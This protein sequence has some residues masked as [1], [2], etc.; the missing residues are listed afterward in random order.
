MRSFARTFMRFKPL[1]RPAIQATLDAS[2][3]KPHNVQCGLLQPLCTP[4][5]PCRGFARGA[6]RGHKE[7]KKKG[8]KSKKGKGKGGK[9][10]TG[11]KNDIF[12]LDSDELQMARLIDKFRS[13]LEEIRVGRASPDALDHIKVEVTKGEE[14]LPL[15]VYASVSSRTAR[16]LN[17]AVHDPSHI[18]A[19]ERAIN[20]STL[21][22]TT[23]PQQNNVV[24]SFPKMTGEARNELSKVLSRKAELVR[25]HLR[26]VRQKT[27]ERAKR[28]DLTADEHFE[29][30]T[31]IQDLLDEKVDEISE[32]YDAKDSE[33]NAD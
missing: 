26:A 23:T 16:S 21:E 30:K 12:P 1:H 9:Q 15:V 28:A 19:V 11:W 8:K 7:P 14:K 29:V 4:F 2:L 3:F 20:Q 25:G 17:V 32:L 5:Q 13:D 18:D 27:Q 31:F 10:Q 33:I 24:V 22:V 6:D